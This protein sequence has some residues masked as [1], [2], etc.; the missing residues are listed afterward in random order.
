MTGGACARPTP[1]ATS[2]GSPAGS[3][4]PPPRCT[5]TWPPR[6]APTSSARTR[7][8]ELTEQMFRKLDL[9]V[10][11]VPELAK[12]VDMISDAYSE[13]A[14]LSGPF[15]VQR[16]HGDYHLGQVLRTET[17][18]VVLDFEG[19]P[20]DPLA[21]RRARS[22]PLRDVAGMLRSFDYAARHQLIGHPG[23][24][25][26]SDAA[27]D[28]VRRNASAFCVGYAE[29]GGL[30]PVGQ[31]GPAA[32]AAAGQGRLR[33]AVRGQ[34]PTV[35]AVHPARLT[36]RVLT[37]L[38]KNEN[39][40]VSLGEIER[41]V[42]G[43]HHDPHSVLGAHPA[44]GDGPVA[45]GTVIRALRPLAASVTVVLP[46]GS[47]HPMTHRHLGVFEVLVPGEPMGVR[48]G[49][50][51][52]GFS[53]TG[54]QTRAPLLRLEVAYVNG[55]PQRQDDPYRYLPTLGELDLYLIGEGRHEQLWRA[56]GRRGHWRSTETAGHRRSPSGRRTRAASGSS[57][58]STSGTGGRYPM[59]SLGGAGVWELFVPGVGAG[60]HVQVLD[61]RPGRGV[62]GEGRPDG[63]VRRA[64]ARH[65]VGRL[66][67][68]LRVGRRRLA[69]RARRPAAAGQR[70][71]RSTRC[72]SGRGGPGCPTAT[73]PTELVA[74]V[75]DIGFT[76]VEFLPVAEHP[77]GGSWGY[78]V[79]SY[80]APTVAVRHP[81]RL[82]LPRRHAAPGG[83]RR[84]RRLGARALPARLLGARRV[85]RHPPVR[86]RRPPAR[87]AAGLGHAR[88][89]LR[90]LARCGTSSSP[91][92][93]T[94]SRSS[95]STGCGSTR[96]RRC[97]TWTTR[98]NDGEWTPNKLRRPGE[99]G[100]DLVPAGGQRHLPT[101]GS[102]GS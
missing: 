38:S 26:L 102:R 19:E 46:D 61:L 74:Y 8:G 84:H 98:G 3:A 71:C 78:Q 43:Q 33:S 20:A 67:V 95:T 76:H 55:E 92:P 24:A 91:T 57:A 25:A 5:P 28:W 68:G 62:A 88:V 45:E 32:R 14:K 90:P 1:A 72:T 56:L 58:T 85:R 64:A 42:A 22:S 12:H 23:Q 87:D 52:T 16:V 81:G 65:R 59:R 30:D 39:E 15:P 97:C 37:V 40:T 50:I 35:L 11:A 86:A 101:G 2:P 94:G 73:S 82:P 7:S 77:F 31:P 27:R 36:G 99:P 54:S 6:S 63:R 44:P 17:G 89:Q 75:T 66:R 53:G 100:G 9:A 83:H 80:Y 48:H 4:S 60:R 18:W 70:R 34:A 79:T 96:S 69:G 41:L 10:A 21:Q 93:S 49:V 51:G 13:L 47:R 29:A